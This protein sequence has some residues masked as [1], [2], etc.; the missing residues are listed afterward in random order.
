MPSTRSDN[1]LITPMRR[2][3]LDEIIEIEG[4]SFSMP[5][6]RKSFEIELSREYAS[7]FVLREKGLSGESVLGYLC[8]WQV[9][10]EVH[11]LN[12]AVRRS[13]RRR[14]HAGR[15]IEAAI[16]HHGQKQV[17]RFV[18]EVRENNKAGI[19]LYESLGFSQWG[20]KRRYYADTGEDALIYGL[21]EP[22][23]R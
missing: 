16:A 15:L 10:E 2:E 13:A 3:D 23:G 19:A 14:G 12:L 11:I 21:G 7:T 22:Q 8:A 9:M 6:P 5:W 18:L 20:V 17:K 4:A 1:L